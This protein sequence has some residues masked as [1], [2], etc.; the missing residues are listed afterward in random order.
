MVTAPTS[1]DTQYPL[2]ACFAGRRPGLITKHRTGSSGYSWLSMARLW[3][4]WRNCR[5]QVSRRAG[6]ACGAGQVAGGVRI[7][8]ATFFALG[9]GGGAGTAHCP[10][11][12][13]D[14]ERLRAIAVN[15]EP[16][17]EVITNETPGQLVKQQLPLP[18]LALLDG[19][20]NR[21]D[22]SVADIEI[23]LVSRPPPQGVRIKPV[24]CRQPAPWARNCSG[25]GC[26][27]PS[28]MLEN[29]HSQYQAR[30]G[31]P[32]N[33]AGRSLSPRYW[34]LADTV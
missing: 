18:D 6:R 8:L 34:L 33:S 27:P 4:L 9:A 17:A 14:G 24:P 16:V 2:N 10:D 15:R 7:Q 11:R 5:D 13:L 3:W 25:N 30:G 31:T 28:R 29:R 23:E 22:K 20:E 1:R 12:P 26:V 32:E 19:R 21:H